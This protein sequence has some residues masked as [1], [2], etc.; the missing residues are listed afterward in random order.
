MSTALELRLLMAESHCVTAMN[1]MLWCDF[2]QQIPFGVVCAQI[3]LHSFY[4]YPRA[5]TIKDKF[6]V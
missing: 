2:Y 4:I 1:A 3:L 5:D 6:K